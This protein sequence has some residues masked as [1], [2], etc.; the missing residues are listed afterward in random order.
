[1]KFACKTTSGEIEKLH[2]RI[3]V[4][5]L[6]EKNAEVLAMNEI[7]LVDVKLTEPM[8]FDAYSKNKQTG[9][10]IIIDRLSNLTLGAGM[11]EAALLSEEPK[12]EQIITGLNDFELE[13]IL[14]LR[15]HFPQLSK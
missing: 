10:F 9:A 14:L 8:A 7:G 3:D 13:L 11:I 4:N 2:H 6:A 5:T 12:D 1:I 15:K